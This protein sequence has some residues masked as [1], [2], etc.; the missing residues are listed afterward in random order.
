MEQSNLKQIIETETK[1]VPLTLMYM[2]AHFTVLLQAGVAF[3]C[4][5]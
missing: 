3:N 5:L 1:W 2:T 4:V